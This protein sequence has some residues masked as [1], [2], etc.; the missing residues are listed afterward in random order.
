MARLGNI[1][2]DD[3]SVNGTD[4]R[5]LTYMLDEEYHLYARHD[6]PAETLETDSKIPPG[7][8]PVMGTDSPVNK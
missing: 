6:K 7:Q 5:K 3:L 2:V 1:Q 8:N 4:A